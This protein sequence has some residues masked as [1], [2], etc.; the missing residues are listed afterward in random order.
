[1]KLLFINPVNY[2]S[3]YFMNVVFRVPYLGPYHLA[4][5]TPE[6]ID[7]EVIDEAA[8]EFIPED[9]EGKAD[10]AVVSVNFTA[11]ATKGYQVADKLRSLGLKVIIGGNHASYCPE[12]AKRHADSVCIGEADEIWADIVEDLRK[13]QLKPLYR[14]PRLPDLGN[15]RFLRKNPLLDAPSINLEYTATMIGKKLGKDTGAKFRK[16]LNI[17]AGL[18]ANPRKNLR[19]LGNLGTS[20]LSASMDGAF[21][22]ILRAPVIGQVARFVL[23]KALQRFMYPAIFKHVDL[24][25]GVAQVP[26]GGYLVKKVVQLG[27]GCP[28]DCEFCSVTA[29]NGKRYRHYKLDQLVSDIAE[30]AGD[31]KGLD[32]FF[33]FADDNIVAD[34]RFAKEFF[35]EIKPLKVYW[36]SQA[37]IQMARD[38][39]LLELAADAGCVGIFYGLETLKQDT[40]KS[41]DKGFKVK[42]YEEVIK[43]THD[44]GIA[45]LPAAFVFGLQGDTLEDFKRTADFCVQNRIELPQFSILNPLP[46][47]RLWSRL[48]GDSLP[49]ESQWERYTFQTVTDPSLVPQ[50]MT[51]VELVQGW[52]DA[53]RRVVSKDAIKRRIGKANFR[54]AFMYAATYLMN[55]LYTGAYVYEYGGF[56]KYIEESLSNKTWSPQ[57]DG[58]QQETRLV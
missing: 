51:P 13:N 24:H 30:L 55:Y 57:A 27:R 8:V 39:E 3:G 11:S 25:E 7:V 36:Y 44:K 32:R 46:G 9:Y 6:D 31:G 28:V 10:V 38:E 45:V 58:R 35:K 41:V 48:Y 43:R 52:I 15:V 29:F 50:G 40:L 18:D 42:D 22:P 20:F 2:S 14:A 16:E 49:D 5:L 12:E 54:T 21:D 47:T 19:K 17:G 53:Y 37:T 34:P 56:L 1:M 23:H 26:L 4:R 33:V